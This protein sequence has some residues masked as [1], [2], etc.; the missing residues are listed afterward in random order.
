MA[1]NPLRHQRRSAW[2]L[3][4]GTEAGPAHPATQCRTS[5][6]ATER[7]VREAISEHPTFQG[8]PI[9]EY[10]E[11]SYPNN[12]NVRTES[13]VDISVQCRDATCTGTSPHNVCP[14]LSPSYSGIWNPSRLRS[15]VAVA[16]QAK[17]PGQLDTRGRVAIKVNSS[18]VRVD[19]DVVPCFHYR[20][21]TAP[22]Y[23]LA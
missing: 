2:T 17:F 14:S 15:E 18:T 19:A 10:A 20:D 16:L 9:A 21:Y 7:M 1:T 11:G 12:T 4:T 5:K 3:K 23:Y 13:D 8:Y 6:I 22:N